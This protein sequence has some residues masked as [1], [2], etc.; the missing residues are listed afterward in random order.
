MAWPF[1]GKMPVRTLTQYDFSA[2]VGTSGTV[3]A[4]QLPTGPLIFK[5][6]QI[7]GGNLSAISIRDSTGASGGT[8][9]ANISPASGTFYD[10][11]V[12]MNNISI[13]ASGATTYTL[14]Y[15]R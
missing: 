11:S 8:L 3:S 14:I 1:S 5:G 6:L 10:Y 2:V 4:S 9:L 15:L 12:K 13:Y 7:N